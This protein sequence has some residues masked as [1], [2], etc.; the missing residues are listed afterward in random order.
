MKALEAFFPKDI[1]TCARIL[2]L[3]GRSGLDLS[4]L[5]SIAANM[6][7]MG[8]RGAN[9]VFRGVNL[10]ETISG[11]DVL[12]GIGWWTLRVWRKID[13]MMVKAGVTNGDVTAFVRAER[14]KWLGLEKYGYAGPL[15]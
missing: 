11:E 6:R 7:F 15:E 2:D 13:M 14:K 8:G 12:H 9:L 10:D 1:R 4:D 5:H 3:L